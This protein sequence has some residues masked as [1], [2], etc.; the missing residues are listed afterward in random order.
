M[1]NLLVFAVNNLLD[2]FTTQ[3]SHAGNRSLIVL[4]LFM[5]ASELGALNRQLRGL[6]LTAFVRDSS[7]NDQSSRQSSGPLK[8]RNPISIPQLLKVGGTRESAMDKL[9][10]PDKED[11]GEV[12]RLGDLFSEVFDQNRVVGLTDHDKRPGASEA[13]KKIARERKER[14]TRV[15]IT[16]ILNAGT[17]RSNLDGRPFPT[18]LPNNYAVFPPDAQNHKKTH[19]SMGC[20]SASSVYAPRLGDDDIVEVAA[21]PPG[22]SSNTNEAAARSAIST[23]KTTLSETCTT[24]DSEEEEDPDAPAFEYVSGAEEDDDEDEDGADSDV[25]EVPS[26]EKPPL[27]VTRTETSPS[28]LRVTFNIGAVPGERAIQR[29]PSGELTEGVSGLQ[30]RSPDATDNTRPMTARERAKAN[31]RAA[32]AAAVKKT[33][34]TKF[35]PKPPTDSS[36]SHDYDETSS[37]E[38]EAHELARQTYQGIAMQ[39]QTTRP[40]Q[41]PGVGRGQA[42]KIAMQRMQTQ[43]AATLP[44]MDILLQAQRQRLQGISENDQRR[45]E[46]AAAQSERAEAA[47]QR[48]DQA[49][50]LEQEANVRAYE[51]NRR[52]EQERMRQ[53]EEQSSYPRETVSLGNLVK[54]RSRTKAKFGDFVQERTRSKSREGQRSRSGKRQRDVEET[55]PS[56]KDAPSTRKPSDPNRSV[57]PQDEGKYQHYSQYVRTQKENFVS[58]V[59]KKTPTSSPKG[60]T[61]KLS[62]VVRQVPPARATSEEDR[63]FESRLN[64]NWTPL[65]YDDGKRGHFTKKDVLYGDPTFREWIRRTTNFNHYKDELRTLGLFGRD[66]AIEHAKDIIVLVRAKMYAA[67]FGATTPEPSPMPS[68]LKGLISTPL[69]AQVPRL[70]PEDHRMMQNDGRYVGMLGWEVL[71]SQLQYLYDALMSRRKGFVYG[72]SLRPHSPLVLWALHAFNLI[73]VR[74]YV[75]RW[76]VIEN[77]YTA[78]KRWNQAR[79]MVEQARLARRFLPGQIEAYDRRNVI[80]NSTANSRAI[81]DFNRIRVECQEQQLVFNRKSAPALDL[82][83][84]VVELPD[85]D[86][87]PSPAP[88]KRTAQETVSTPVKPSIVSTPVKPST[89]TTSSV[90]TDS[91][92]SNITPKVDDTKTEEKMELGS[93]QES[94]TESIKEGSTNDSLQEESGIGSTQGSIELEDVYTGVDPLKDMNEMMSSPGETPMDTTET[95]ADSGKSSQD[96]N[97]I[98]EAIVEGV[99]GLDSTV[100]ESNTL[101][102]E[103]QGTTGRGFNPHEYHP[104]LAS[105]SPLNTADEEVAE[106]YFDDP[107]VPVAD[108]ETN[109]LLQAASTAHGVIAVSYDSH[110]VSENGRKVEQNKSGVATVATQP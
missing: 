40:L 33:E 110:V 64:P 81:Q 85:E 87:F 58:P 73:M 45:R 42:L 36:P 46:R 102:K 72:G 101:Q 68:W 1:T 65:C 79:S 53:R 59:C 77:R 107:A 94:N 12:G 88:K 61:L 19:A 16:V 28:E 95:A 48:V 6:R 51:E 62:S 78:W 15:V 83:Q 26:E 31:V 75:V 63:L 55:R 105:L 82:S 54:D 10:S 49:H 41:V 100:F 70:S 27:P 86:W 91:G 69:G 22:T 80:V 23:P 13:N 76:H 29:T 30:V 24:N 39:I 17:L 9:G 71:L 35:R 2:R 4:G 93:S 92:K 52:A 43:K 96:S 38:A 20:G 60:K 18:C 99:V 3:G 56:A 66:K 67:A 44:N 57:R 25:V 89:V 11:Y 8:T 5:T 98:S 106:K 74:P 97:P 34:E 84:V 104:T 90:S 50:R 37:I 7:T 103:Y 21:I 108:T 14:E 32:K 47:L 109:E